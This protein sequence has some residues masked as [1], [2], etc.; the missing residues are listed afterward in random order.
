MP[1]EGR[2]SS[3]AAVDLISGTRRSPQHFCAD[4]VATPQGIIGRNRISG[5]EGSMP[6]YEFRCKQCGE[7][8]EQRETIAEH[9]T[10]KP[11][12]PKCGGEKVAQAFSAFYANT[13][14][15]G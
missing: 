12:C 15:K 3:R 10:A 5:Q 2:H 7:I 9:E 11:E 13:S 6:T 4:A 14:K 1:A 8:F